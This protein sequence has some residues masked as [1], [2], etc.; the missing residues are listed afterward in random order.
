[1]A[2]R[3]RE[4]ISI[5][6]PCYNE[7][8]AIPFFYKEIDRISQVMKE[9]TDF[10][11][12]FVDDGSKDGTMA[13]LRE[14]AANDKRVRYVSFS[15]NFG[16]EAAMYA[17][18]EN[19]RGDLVAILDADL[20][21]PPSLL[22]EMYASIKN[23]GYD[24]VA[25]RRS[26][27]KGEP[28]LRSFFARVFY[29][30]MNRISKTELVEGAR[31]FRLM[32]RQMVDSVLS[33]CEYNRFTKGIFTWVGYKTRWIEYENVERVAGETKW[34]FWKLFKYSL[35]CIMAFSTVPLALSS[36]FGILF[37]LIAVIGIVFVI[38]RQA[39]WGGSAYGWASTVCIILFVAGIQLFCIGILGQ[40]LAKTYLE[41]KKRPIYIAK[42]TEKAI[43]PDNA[44]AAP[45]SGGKE[46]L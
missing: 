17:G 14:L 28:K 10:E 12:L 8:A 41:T 31:D 29:K 20:Q 25:T 13:V 7:Q 39:V 3:K 45:N 19:A 22:P 43:R 38:V 33:V 37:S 26:T 6:V 30:L 11:L 32:T 23:D 1:M 24:S 5:I 36:F 44:D 35:E 34:S 18:L 40:Y 16:K 42:E 2:E 9:E 4:L 15:R 46:N 27:R 21:D